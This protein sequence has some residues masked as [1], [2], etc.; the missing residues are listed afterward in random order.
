MAPW[1]LTIAQNATGIAQ[2]KGAASDTAWI[3]GRDP[4]YT[5][6]A[7]RWMAQIIKDFGSDHVWQMDGFFANGSSWGLEL[8]ARGDRRALIVTLAI[9]EVAS[10]PLRPLRR[11]LRT[12]SPPGFGAASEKGFKRQLFLTACSYL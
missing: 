6:V 8:T 4:L 7:D 11:P 1:E 10:L 5:A 12:L 3:D 2:G 9:V